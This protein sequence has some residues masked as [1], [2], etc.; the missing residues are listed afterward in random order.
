MTEL[1]LRCERCGTVGS[2]IVPRPHMVEI[3]RQATGWI[4]VDGRVECPDHKPHRPIAKRRGKPG[5]PW[6]PADFASITELRAARVKWR[7][8]TVEFEKKF[9]R[10]L[11]PTTVMR[12]WD[13]WIDRGATIPPQSP[14]RK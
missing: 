4:D 9:G 7:Q 13:R 8:I 10:H 6:S 1:T 3:V 2:W 11:G 12:A 14:L 5:L